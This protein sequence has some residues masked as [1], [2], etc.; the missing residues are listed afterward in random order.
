MF[1]SAHDSHEQ[2]TSSM[3]FTTTLLDDHQTLWQ[4]NLG[5][6]FLA[7]TR[8]GTIDDTVFARWLRQDYRFVEAA[9]PMLGVLISKAPASHREPL[10]DA[11]SGLYDELDL[12]QE[13]AET[14]GI[15]LDDAK[16]A[17]T[18][19]AYIQFLLATARGR[20]YLKGFTVLYAAEKAYYEAWSRVEEGLSPDA[21][22]AP[23]VEN[24]ASDGFGEYVGFLA[25]TLDDLAAKA[26]P[27]EKSEMHRLFE[28]TLRYEAAFWEMAYDTT[29]WPGLD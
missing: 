13:R 22:A 18:C 3:S 26:G 16:P 4:A 12:F 27:Q 19:H 20:S 5:H 24:W 1:A 15:D 10:T 11:L 8:D 21:F 28:T 6:R 2:T 25:T 14:A 9:C 17:F 23:F 7:E 29:D